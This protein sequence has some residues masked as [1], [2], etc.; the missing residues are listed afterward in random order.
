M[1]DAKANTPRLTLEEVAIELDLPLTVVARLVEEGH[2]WGETVTR[3]GHTQTLFLQSRIKTSRLWLKTSE[4]MAF[5]NRTVHHIRHLI[6]TG[7]VQGKKRGGVWMV[8]Y[9]SLAQWRDRKRQAESTLSVSDVAHLAGLTRPGVHHLIK[10]R[11]LR[12]MAG[13]PIRFSFRAVEKF[14]RSRT[15]E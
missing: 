14:L 4:A 2:L 3:N 8:L 1:G 10:R 11:K 6:V 15:V 13:K 12:P 5:T 7:A 9:Q